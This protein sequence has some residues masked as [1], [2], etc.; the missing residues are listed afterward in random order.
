MKF[1]KDSVNDCLEEITYGDEK[2][3]NRRIHSLKLL[4]IFIVLIGGLG[5]FSF[6]LGAL[7][8]IIDNA[9]DID[10]LSFS[11]KGYATTTYDTKGNLTATLIQEGS[12][13]EAVTYEE[14]PEQLINAFVAIEDQRF[15]QHNGIDLRS[16]SRAVKGVITGDSSAGG[17][18]T[19]TQQLIKNNVFSG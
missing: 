4:L 18:S 6:G 12:N 8:G 9:P 17:G 16:I 10:N 14:I 7:I 1:T 11:P 3:D 2:A 5:A 15:W 19:L 13:R